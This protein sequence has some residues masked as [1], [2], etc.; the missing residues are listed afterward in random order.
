MKIK[1]K[2]G[3]ECEID[4]EK[5]LDF[6]LSY[7]IG[8]LQTDSPEE[9]VKDTNLLVNKIIGKQNV[10]E[11]FESIKKANNGVVKQEA[12]TD[13]LREILNKLGADSKK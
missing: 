10:K 7:L 3:F 12:V 2:E 4:K 9:A 13:A 5:V 11:F 8:A 1:T 6:E